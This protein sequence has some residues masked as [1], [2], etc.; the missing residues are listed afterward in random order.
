MAKNS[1]TFDDF[2]AFI[3]NLDASFRAASK[4]TAKDNQLHTLGVLAKLSEDQKKSAIK[5][6]PKGLN[7][8]LEKIFIVN[9]VRQIISFC[10]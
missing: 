10:N 1:L 4:N 6:I 7:D 5:A 2:T 3:A 9:Y 8:D